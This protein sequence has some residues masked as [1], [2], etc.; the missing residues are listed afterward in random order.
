MA[1]PAGLGT[2]RETR[3][4]LAA[5]PDDRRA[6]PTR[7]SELARPA[8]LEPAA[9]SLEGSCSIHLSYGRVP[10]YYAERALPP[11]SRSSTAHD[12]HGHAHNR[13]RRRRRVR[14]TDRMALRAAA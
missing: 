7:A 8:G 10:P 9:P 1:R 13:P 12:R 14:G 6:W 3:E 5:L 11:V 2:A 4:R